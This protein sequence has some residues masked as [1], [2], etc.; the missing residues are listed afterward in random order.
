VAWREIQQYYLAQVMEF[1]IKY[2]SYP[3]SIW[4]MTCIPLKNNKT[5]SQ[6]IIERYIFRKCNNN[7][8]LLIIQLNGHI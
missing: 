3:L 7:R 1:N 5:I 8:L 4:H 2:L 6:S